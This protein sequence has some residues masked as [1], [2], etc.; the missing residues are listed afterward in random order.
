MKWLTFIARIDRARDTF[1]LNHIAVGLDAGYF[2]AAVCHH[3]EERQLI[4][5]MGYRRPTKKKLL[6]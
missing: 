5:V 4:G 1:K 6:R 2:T 3:L